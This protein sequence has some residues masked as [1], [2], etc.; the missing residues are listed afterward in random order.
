M[1]PNRAVI[2][3]SAPLLLGIPPDFLVNRSIED[4]D[5]YDMIALTVRWPSYVDCV[6]E[7]SNEG[8]PFG[9]VS[10]PRFLG[11]RKSK[12]E[13]AQTMNRFT[14]LDKTKP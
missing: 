1:L 9:A 14:T 10:I 4:E 11:I 5:D 3:A 12:I 6:Q 7:A 13:A 2:L 8:S